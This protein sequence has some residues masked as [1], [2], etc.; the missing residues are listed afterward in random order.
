[1]NTAAI[2]VRLLTGV[3]LGVFFYSALWFTVRA[4]PTSR[5]PVLLTLGSFWGRTIGVLAVFLFLMQ[6]RWEYAAACLAGF[7]AGRLAVSRMLQKH[8]TFAP[9]RH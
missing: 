9:R 3:A 8:K 1:M 7:M 2:V 6:N 5:H 4:L